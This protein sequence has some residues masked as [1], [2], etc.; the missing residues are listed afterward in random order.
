MTLQVPCACVL[1]MQIHGAAK[2]IVR[3]LML[4]E[5]LNALMPGFMRS[6]AVVGIFRAL[7][8]KLPASALPAAWW[9]V[10]ADVAVMVGVHRH[11]YNNYESIRKDPAL[12]KAFQVSFWLM[13]NC[14]WKMLRNVPAVRVSVLHI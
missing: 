14:K 5:E 12:Q 13:L 2:S 1:L 11:G 6:E 3:R 4:L 10:E 8:T 7:A 9:D